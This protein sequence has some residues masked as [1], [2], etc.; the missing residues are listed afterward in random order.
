MTLK[1][2]LCYHAR[3][4]VSKPLLDRRG[5]LHPAWLGRSRGPPRPAP[6]P[7]SC[8]MP[9][10]IRWPASSLGGLAVTARERGVQS[11]SWT[12]TRHGHTRPTRRRRA[13]THRAG[14]DARGARR[15]PVPRAPALSLGLPQGRR[16]P[17]SDDRPRPG[18]ARDAGRPD[19]GLHAGGRHDGR[20]ERRHDE[21]RAGARRRAADRGRVHPRH[22]AP[23][24][25]HFHAGRLRDE[26]RVLPDREDGP[27]AQPDGGRDCRPGARARPGAR[28]ARAPVQHRPHGHG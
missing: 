24:L 13:G 27:G 16:R 28:P 18:P 20:L 12:T 22:P 4:A 23:D 9:F 25:L 26:V 10:R 19:P 3:P 8:P 7:R 2:R 1:E 15:P 5:R 14:A 17:R 21:V 6:L 11:I